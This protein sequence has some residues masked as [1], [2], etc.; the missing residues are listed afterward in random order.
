MYT[1]YTMTEINVSARVPTHLE[2]ELERYMKE[3]HLERSVAI[4]KLLFYSLQRWREDYALKLLE[5]GKT[6]ISKA[7]EIAGVNI[8]DFAE[9]I[10]EKKIRWIKDSVIDEDLASFK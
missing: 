3:E 5:E 4:R 10:K 6:T 1:L 7:A 2:K 9:K 8:W